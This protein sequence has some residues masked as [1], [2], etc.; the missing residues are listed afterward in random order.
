MLVKVKIVVA[1]RYWLIRFIKLI[2]HTDQLNASFGDPKSSK[3]SDLNPNRE[4]DPNYKIRPC[5]GRIPI[6]LITLDPTKYISTLYGFDIITNLI[7]L[8][9]VTTVK[10]IQ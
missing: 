6:D 10:S 9:A 1:R 8:S 4:L 7:K 5:F 3:T 2:I